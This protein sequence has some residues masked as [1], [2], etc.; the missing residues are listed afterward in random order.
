M[1]TGNENGEVDNTSSESC[2]VVGLISDMS[3]F[4][5]LLLEIKFLGDCV[6]VVWL[7]KI[8]TL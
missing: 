5:V 8:F 1:V 2:L 6:N 3:K 4:L 7:Y